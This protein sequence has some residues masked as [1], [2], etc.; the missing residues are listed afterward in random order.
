MQI[1]ICGI[2][3]LVDAQQALQLG[4]DAIGCV[5]YGGSPRAVSIDQA[6]EISLGVQGRGFMVGLFVDPEERE[7]RE[8]LASVS[9][10][11]LQFHGR[12]PAEFCRRFGAPYIKA[13]PMSDSVDLI[14][15]RRRYSDAKALLLDSV[16]QGQFGG[17]GKRFDWSWIPDSM[18]QDIILAGGLCPDT[19]G[20]A[21]RVVRPC[22]VDVSSGVEEAPGKKSEHKMRA[23]ITA[24]RE[25]EQELTS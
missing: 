8:V 17:T 15:F 25:A 12:E 13:V 21:I 1:K 5:F 16:A 6:K 10:D 3:R 19:V 11:L 18:R 2:T 24:A 7:V 23:F 4:A 14:D 20:E 22:A 9:L